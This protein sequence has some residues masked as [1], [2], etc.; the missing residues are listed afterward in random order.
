MRAILL[1]AKFHVVA[2]ACVLGAFRSFSNEAQMVVI[3]SQAATTV[4]LIAGG[5]IQLFTSDRPKASLN[6]VMAFVA[7]LVLMC[8]L[9]VLTT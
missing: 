5:I 8:L 1:V 2:V 6:F 9:P 3:G 4:L 7:L